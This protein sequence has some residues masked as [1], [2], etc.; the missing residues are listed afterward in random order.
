MAFITKDE[1]K[2]HLYQENINTISGDDP[3]LKVI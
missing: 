3:K 1:L 2:T